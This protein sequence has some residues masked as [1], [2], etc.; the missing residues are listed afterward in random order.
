MHKPPVLEASQVDI[1]LS[2]RKIIDN[3]SFKLAGSEYFGIVGPNG[4]GK[5]TL[6]KALLG[7]L[8]PSKG[9]ISING[10][11]VDRMKPEERAQKISYVQQ[12][13]A[14]D[15]NFN[16]KE[17]IMLG[18][19]PHQRVESHQIAKERFEKLV[20]YFDLAQHLGQRFN[21]LSG[22]ERQ[23][24]LLVQSLY[25]NPSILLLDEV[26]NHLDI[27]YQLEILK[28][29]KELPIMKIIVLHDLNHALRFCD[30]ILMLSEGRMHS[31][32]SPEKVLAPGPIKSVYGVNCRLLR[33]EEAAPHLYYD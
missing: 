15:L 17:F 9:H 33:G 29:L 10:Q 14:G 3:V 5:S 13:G 2:Q 7:F 26:T 4:S 19:Y 32:G 18:D 24:V 16:V 22:G 1:W 28:R 6:L 12:D 30:R 8:T 25:Q 27:Y 11:R 23:R 31:L 21:D 20:E